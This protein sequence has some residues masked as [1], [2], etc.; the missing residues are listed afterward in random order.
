[1]EVRE[2]YQKQFGVKFEVRFST[3]RSSTHTLAV[4]GE[5]RPFRDRAG[6]LVFRP[7]GHGSLLENLNA[8]K[9]DLVYIKNID[10]VTPEHLTGGTVYWK[11]ALGGYLVM[12]QDEIFKCLGLLAAKKVSPGVLSKI[13]AFARKELNLDLG[14]GFSRLPNAR[15]IQRL[16]KALNRPIRVCGVVPNT[17]E[18]GGGPFWVRGEEGRQS[19]QIVEGAQ[20]D[21]GD[22]GQKNIFEESTHF[23]PVDLVCGVRNWRGKPFNLRLFR[24]PKA[25]FISRKSMGGKEL[26]ALELPGLWNGAM[27]GWITLFVEVPLETFNPV[28]TVFDLLKPAHQVKV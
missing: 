22:K 12:V 17:G 26:K 4:D 27:A 9:G 16:K 10:N 5:N 1:M 11:K 7:S 23:N 15:K 21:M 14:D 24:D 3:Q 2:K 18:P 8:L 6:Q 28:K 20:V 19:L 13:A 25:V